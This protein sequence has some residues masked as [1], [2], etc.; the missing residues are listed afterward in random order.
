MILLYEVCAHVEYFTQ[1]R[2]NKSATVMYL[3]VILVHI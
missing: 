3:Y 1:Y 2:H